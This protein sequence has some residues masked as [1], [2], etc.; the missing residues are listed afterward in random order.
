M[1]RFGS[2]FTIRSTWTSRSPMT[3]PPS[4]GEIPVW[5]SSTFR[6]LRLTL[7]SIVRQSP[8]RYAQPF[9]S[10]TWW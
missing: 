4:I 5:N 1:I 3:K 10:G 7:T 8:P 9:A 2:A 6:P